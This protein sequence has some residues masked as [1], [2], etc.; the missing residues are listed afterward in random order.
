MTPYVMM[1]MD[2]PSDLIEMLKRKGEKA[3]SYIAG[4]ENR[5][6]PPISDH[7]TRAL[8]GIPDLECNHCSTS[9]SG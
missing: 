9:G 8:T 2:S 7:I 1:T 5:T 3:T 6:I 4:A